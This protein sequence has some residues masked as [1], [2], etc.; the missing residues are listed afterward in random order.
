Y[1]REHGIRVRYL[2]SDI[3]A[4]ER[5]AI[6]R[7][8]RLG[9]FDVLV[10]INLLREGLDLPEVGLVAI[11]DADKEGYLRSVTSLVQ[12]IGRAARNVEGT[13][14]MYADRVTESMQ[15]AISETERRRRIQE[16]YNRA[17]HITPQTVQ[18]A[19]RDVIQATRQT[20][21]ALPDKKV[22]DLTARERVKLINQI[23]KEMKEASRNWEFER[24][25]MLRDML[26]ELEKEQPVKKVSGGRRRG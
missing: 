11:L 2:H 14:I 6:I 15:H 24:A 17:H 7:D 1:L 4:L 5:M 25:A 26:L 10:G 9:E 20:G 21:P 16:E 8:L 13:V 23:R 3:D 22:Q 19:V 18:K 12:T